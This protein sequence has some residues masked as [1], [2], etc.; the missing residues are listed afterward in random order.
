M[1]PRQRAWLLTVLAL[2]VAFG[3]GARGAGAA[4][5]AP[6]R[7]WAVGVQAFEDGLYDLA[8]DQLGRF[9]RVAPTD[10]RRG[11]AAF[12]RGKAAFALGR[13]AD[14]LTEFQ[15]AEALP[16]RVIAVGEPFYWQAE[17]LFRLRRFE[18]ARERYT[19]FL[20]EYPRSAQAADALYARGFAELELGRSDEALASFQTL[21]R[22]HVGSDLAGSAAYALAREL[23]RLKR[24]SEAL[25]LLSTY[26]SRFPKS[27]FLAEARYLLGITQLEAGRSAEGVRT[28]EQFVTAAPAHDLAPQARWVLAESHVRAGRTR[29]ALDHYQ[30]LAKHAPAH[31]L[32]PQALYHAGDLA[33][34]LGRTAEAEAAWTALRRAHPQDAL[35]GAAGLDLASLYLKR[36]QL[37]QAIEL[38]REVAEAGGPSR[39]EAL[40][41]LGES[42]LRA[43]KTPEA[44]RAY[45]TALAEAPERSGERFRALAGVGLVAEVQKDSAAARRAY[46]EIVRDSEDAELTRWAKTRLQGLEARDKP[47]PKEAPKTKPRPK[48][49]K[50]GGS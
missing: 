49:K 45:E 24:W 50:A 11:D 46:Q 39:L 43:G 38:A 15:A 27:R 29:E 14:A 3:A 31:P 9:A 22:D 19:V 13:F 12:L 48:P 26:A 32:A 18:F 47:V 5:P 7:L 10:P 6:D 8:Y 33:Q 34:R 25:P 23:V 21:L 35:A 40:L 37:D 2:G 36:R 28:L 16:L 44:V 4:M 42:A 20:R 41:T 30:A 17:T 1:R